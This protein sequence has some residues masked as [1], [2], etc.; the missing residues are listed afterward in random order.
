MWNTTEFEKKMEE[1]LRKE[2]GDEKGP[3][4]YTQ[5]TS[6]RDA[7]LRDN[8]FSQ[9]NGAEPSLSDHGARHIENVLE[10]VGRLLGDEIENQSALTL[11]CLGLVVLFH[12]VGNVFKRK[13]H[14]K[15]ISEVYNF[16]RNEVDRYNHERT[17]VIKAGEAHCGLNKEGGNDTLKFLEEADYLDGRPINLRNI[18]AI[19]RLA[20]E[21]AEGPQR[22]SQFMQEMGL[23]DDASEIFH[24]YASMTEM[25]IDRAL[26]RVA[27]S[28]TVKIDDTT[29]KEGL[30]ELLKFIYHRI[31]KID[32]E[33]RYTKH[34]CDLLSPFK[35]TT[36]KFNFF[37][38]GAPADDL[39]LEKIEITDRFPVPGESKE[40]VNQFLSKNSEIDI[41][42]LWPRIEN[43]LNPKSSENG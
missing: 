43:E 17:L 18:A 38:K 39:D 21:L 33:R 32:E 34:Y 13:Q 19:L 6:A 4:Y 42:N 12:D 3:Q 9:I 40:G 14:N 26:G 7:L 41:D 8:F 31:V 27:I 10:N 22:T 28:Y 5:Y 2:L 23:Y 20:D 35:K 24:K 29:T 36:V 1:R 37:V 16:V 25:Y 15:R 11:Y 30:T